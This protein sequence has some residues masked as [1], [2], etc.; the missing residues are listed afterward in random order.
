MICHLQFEVNGTTWM[1]EKIQIPIKPG[2]VHEATS[3]IIIII[4]IIIIMIIII[5]IMT[6]TIIIISPFGH[7]S[8]SQNPL[9][10]N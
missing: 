3:I 7:V 10:K 8:S 4:I 9:H 6:T 5:I 1:I 2:L